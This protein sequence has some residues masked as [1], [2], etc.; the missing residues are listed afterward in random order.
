MW[1]GQHYGGH[2]NKM[3]WSE[4]HDGG[5]NNN[6]IWSEQHYGGHNNNMI[7][8]E[9][10]YGGHNNNMISHPS[11]CSTIQLIKSKFVWH[12]MSKNICDWAHR[13]NACQ[14]CKIHRHIRQL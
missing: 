3:K 1:S 11:I 5:H 8:S 12:C 6:M 14:R 4:Q 2:N 7:W 9:Q 10:H 13:C